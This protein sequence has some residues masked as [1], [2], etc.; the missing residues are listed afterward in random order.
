[1]NS[2]SACFS[3]FHSKNYRGCTGYGIAS[4]V[5]AFFGGSAIALVGNDT[6]PFIGFQTFGC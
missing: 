2:F 4:G 5:D 6:L 1:M 3:C